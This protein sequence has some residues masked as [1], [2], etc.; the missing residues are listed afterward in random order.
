MI[1]SKLLSK[2]IEIQNYSFT[3]KNRIQHYLKKT[4]IHKLA[5]EI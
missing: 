3:Y 4:S 5:K 2:I 1:S